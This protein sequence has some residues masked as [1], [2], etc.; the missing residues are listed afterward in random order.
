[1]IER[2]VLDFLGALGPELRHQVIFRFDSEERRDWHYIP[3]PRRGVPLRA[4]N[5]AQRGA[6]KALLRTGLSERGYSRV[7]DIMW[8]ENLLAEIERDPE[9]YGPLN[10][11]FSVFGDPAGPGPWGWRVDGHHLSLNFSHLPDKIA[12]T[13]AFFGANPANVEHGP[14]AGLRVLGAE[15]DLGRELIRGLP[16]AQQATAVIADK[17]FKDIITGPGREES[18]RVPKGVAFGAM[19]EAHRGL[20]MR[21]IEEFVGTMRPDAAEAERAR[22]R[23]RGLE[24]IHFAWAGSIEPRRPHYWRLHG[25]NLLIEYDNTQNDANHIHSVWHDPGRDFGAD[26]LRRH[27]EHKPHRAGAF[28]A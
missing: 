11:V 14:H 3:K 16:E 20:A 12:V 19:A 25:P 22:I 17:A 10:Y 23:Q 6:A 26:L 1:M 13:P 27:Y 9:T 2:A 18:L 15:E 28:S 5:E 21:L 7:E 4:M 24:H 8:L